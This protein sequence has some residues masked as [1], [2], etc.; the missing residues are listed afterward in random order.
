MKSIGPAGRQIRV[1]DTDEPVTRVSDWLEMG[2]S[3]AEADSQ[4]LGDSKSYTDQGVSANRTAWMNG[5]VDTLAAAKSYVDT[6]LIPAYMPRG[7]LGTAVDLNLFRAFEQRGKWAVRNS[8]LTNG[9]DL[10]PYLRSPQSSDILWEL[11]NSYG[12]SSMQFQTLRARTDHFNGYFYRGSQGA[13][14][15]SPWVHIGPLEESVTEWHM[16]LAA[17]QSNMVGSGR[18]YSASLD[19]PNPRI[20]ELHP[21]SDRFQTAQV[22]LATAVTGNGLSPATTFAR[23]Y[24]LNMPLHV[25]V[26]I[27]PAARGGSGFDPT[28]GMEYKSWI[29]KTYPFTS[30]TR[31]LYERSVEHMKK[32]L[33]LIGPA[34]IFKGILWHQGENDTPTGPAYYQENLDKLIEDYRAAFNSSNLPFILGQ[35]CPEGMDDSAGDMRAIDRVHYETPRRKKRTAY[36]PAEYGWHGEDTTHYGREGVIRLGRR[37]VQGYFN[38][39]HNLSDTIPLPVVDL[40]TKRV[41]DKVEVSWMP[42]ATRVTAYE[43]RYRAV[44]ASTWKSTKTADPMSLNVTITSAAPIEIQVNTKNDAQSGLPTRTT[45]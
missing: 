41:G 9:P 17:G 2:T 3:V 11:D 36:V 43:V 44:G 6:N 40:K 45:A 23:E 42:T 15:W 5:D 18:P 35:M 27:I 10:R 30:T 32:A 12:N 14:T 13:N 24:L 39:I 33:D 25:G 37:Y 26:V 8:L 38:S 21:S 31:N 29:S 7:Q 19:V 22:P 1:I 16:F 4:V 20:I 28:P 34:G